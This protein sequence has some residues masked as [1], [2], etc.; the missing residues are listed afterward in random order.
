M[1]LINEYIICQALQPIKTRDDKGF[2]KEIAAGSIFYPKHL[3]QVKIL[4]RTGM[5]KVIGS[6]GICTN[7]GKVVDFAEAKRRHN[8][9]RWDGGT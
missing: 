8:E 3:E 5:A 1:D 9:K 7:D 2:I 6:K 4:V